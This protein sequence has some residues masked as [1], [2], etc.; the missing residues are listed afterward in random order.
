[1]N[2]IDSTIVDAARLLAAR[3]ISA[4]ELTR[5]HLDRIERVDPHVRAFVTVTADLALAQ[6][7]EADRRLAAGDGGPLTGV[8]MALKDVI[9]TRGVR[10]TCSSRMLERFVPIY[11]AHVTERLAQAGAVL[12]GK[13]NLDE[14]AMGSSTENSAFFATANPWDLTRVPGGSSGGSAAAVAAR[15]AIFSLGSDTGGSIRQPASLCGVVGVKPTYGRVSRHGLVA[16]ASSL[17]QIGPFTKTVEDA[18]I[19]LEV[20]A[21]HDPRDSTTANVPVPSY[22]AALTGDLRGMRLGVPK[23]YFTEGMEP[24]VAAAIEEA[25]RVIESLGASVDR[26]V[27]MPYTKYALAV[28][29]LIAPSEAS[30]NLARY[31]GVKYGYSADGQTM[32]EEME[33]TRGEG[34]G[35]EV[36]RRIML[37][38]YALSAGYYD[39]YYLKAQKVRTLIKRE[40]DDVFASYDA[41]LTPTSPTVAFK[42]GE[43]AADPVAMY[44]SDV[45]TLPINIAGICGISVPAGFSDGLPVGLQILGRAFDESTILRV[46]HAYEQA[47]PWH[48]RWPELA[49]S[50]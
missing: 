38:A 2:L 33:R 23:E 1:M 30:A 27:S 29:Y 36:K 25:I 3:E 44:L 39:A 7:A 5:A 50:A 37:G 40:F 47:T 15:E 20:I 34:F 14:F 8:P 17:D 22:R 35:P 49:L 26:S 4:V 12:L 11:D 46:A 21:G 28:Y 32:W 48:T 45:C 10:T 13:T 31:D 9:S 43:R 18:A 16:F 24:G 41:L 19:V 42:L 6:A